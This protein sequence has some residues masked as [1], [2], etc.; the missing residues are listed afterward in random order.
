MGWQLTLFGG[1]GGVVVCFRFL[2]LR[3]LLLYCSFCPFLC[4]GWGFFV[5]FC[6]LAALVLL[7]LFVSVCL[8]VG[9]KA[10]SDCSCCVH[11]AV[12]RNTSRVKILQ[13]VDG[14]LYFRT[15]GRAQRRMSLN[16]HAFEST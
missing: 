15:I 8:L 13:F 3:L 14:C 16:K 5:C 12:D 7:L 11:G 1:G 9:G 6:M 2:Y 4:L 10:W